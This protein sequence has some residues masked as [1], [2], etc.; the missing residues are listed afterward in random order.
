MARPAPVQ[1]AILEVMKG[2]PGTPMLSSA[3]RHLVDAHLGTTQSPGSIDSGLTALVH[4]GLIESPPWSGGDGPRTYILRTGVGAGVPPPAARPD[5]APSIPA[6]VSEEI[7]RACGKIYHTRKLAG[8]TDV[9]VL[10]ELRTEGFPFLLTGPPGT[11]KTALVEAA[12]EEA[13]TL[14]GNEETSVETFLGGFTRI[15]RVG[16]EDDAVD[17][18]DDG[19]LVVCAREGRT[20][21]VDDITV[22]SP[23]VLAV[24]Y[25]LMDGRNLLDVPGRPRKL[26]RI[27]EVKDGFYIC[28]AFN[29]GTVGGV[30]SDALASRFLVHINVPT[31]LTLMREKLGVRQ[32]A[33]TVAGNL[34][35]AGEWAP[36]ARELEAATMLEKVV[37]KEYA[38]AN[39]AAVAPPESRQEV[40]DHVRTAYGNDEIYPLTVGDPDA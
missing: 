33:L 29:P 34:T 22:I 26:G 23:L 4:K 25:P 27:V 11:G 15:P 39:M 36:Q 17:A 10:R 38:A 8:R 5:V 30:I 12:F 40:L 32:E 24:L 16:D 2:K 20:L 7:K 1:D 9:V 18:W 3:I 13:I 31:D 28:G 37:G 19:P 35:T 21:F 6:F 14:A